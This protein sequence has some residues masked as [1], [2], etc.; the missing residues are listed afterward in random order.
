MKILRAIKELFFYNPLTK[1]PVENR[2]NY[3]KLFDEVKQLNHI[4]L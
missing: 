1:S 3:I 4:G 2:N